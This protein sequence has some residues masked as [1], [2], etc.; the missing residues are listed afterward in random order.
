MKK[1]WSNLRLP[2]YVNWRIQNRLPRG[3]P[4]ST[5]PQKTK[6]LI[7]IL[8]GSTCTQITSA[9]KSVAASSQEYLSAPHR[10]RVCRTGRRG[11]RAGHA[12]DRARQG[13][14]GA[15]HG[16]AGAAAAPKLERRGDAGD[17]TL[18]RSR[19]NPAALLRT[20]RRRRLPG[21]LHAF[22]ATPALP[23]V[24]SPP[25]PARRR[26]SGWR[27]P[28]PRFEAAPTALAMKPP[29]DSSIRREKRRSRTL[30]SRAR[31]CAGRSRPRPRRCSQI[32]P[33]P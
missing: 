15:V 14:D 6:Y 18:Q 33:R 10:R 5:A 25:A 3:S 1:R 28:D 11:R 29:A 32:R 20:N 9:A 2:L 4:L 24:S 27:T 21:L 17:S 30:L 7:G 31:P 16:A 26:R 22:P 12:G 23:A 8:W 19:T 13:H